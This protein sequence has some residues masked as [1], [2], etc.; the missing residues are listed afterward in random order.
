MARDRIRRLLVVVDEEER[1]EIKRR[2]DAARLSV[3]S[4]LRASG[5]G[6]VIRSRAAERSQ[7][8]SLAAIAMQQADLGRRLAASG[9]EG[10]SL[11][12]E[13]KATQVA[14]RKAA[15]AMVGT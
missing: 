8:E 3:S 9:P 2:A 1:E 11:L 15:E 12:G 10:A 13:I 5:L 6:R 4:Y 14:L 7:V